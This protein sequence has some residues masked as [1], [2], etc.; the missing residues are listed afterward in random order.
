MTLCHGLRILIGKLS[1]SNILRERGGGKSVDR[2]YSFFHLLN[3]RSQPFSRISFHDVIGHKPGFPSY[4]LIYI[5]IANQQASWKKKDI[6]LL[7]LSYDEISTTPTS[8]SPPIL[9]RRGRGGRGGTGGRF[10]TAGRGRGGGRFDVAD[11]GGRGESFGIGRG[12]G[13]S[14]AQRMSSAVEENN[15][16]LDVEELN[17]ADGLVDIDVGLPGRR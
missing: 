13:G 1:P 10:D 3:M 17:V 14:R 9:K 16:G 4:I 6:D 8:C 15:S 5:D 7:T 12:R 11:R 2:G